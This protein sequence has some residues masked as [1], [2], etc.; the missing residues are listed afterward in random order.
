MLLSLVYWLLGIYI[1]Q[2]ALYLPFVAPEFGSPLSHPQSHF[3]K[4]LF[5]EEYKNRII[6]N[7][8][9]LFYVETVGCELNEDK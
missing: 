2:T 7:I 3:V 1:S 9:Y 4:S 8:A 5:P 6:A